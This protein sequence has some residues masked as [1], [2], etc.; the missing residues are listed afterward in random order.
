VADE[1]TNGELQRVFESGK[2]ELAADIAALQ[3]RL[4]MYVLKEVYEVQRLADLDRVAR[5]EKA[6]IDQRTQTRTAFLTA[7]TSFIAPIVVAVV[8]AFFMRGM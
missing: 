2:T 5:L 6:L 7:I 8:V 3:D 1:P 4:S